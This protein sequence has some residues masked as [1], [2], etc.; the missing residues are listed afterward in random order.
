MRVLVVGAGGFVGTATCVALQARGHDVRAIVRRPLPLHLA[1]I[2]QVIVPNVEDVVDWTEFVRDVDAIVYLAARVHVAR[3]TAN[4]AI[5]SYRGVNVLAPVALA[6]AAA[7]CST[8]TFIYASSVKVHGE[9]SENGLPLDATSP[10]RPEGPYA[11]S[12]AEAEAKL[13]DVLCKTRT[14]L[15]VAV[16][17]L[18]Y[19]PGVR[20]N[21]LRLIELARIAQLL[22][23][24]LA[25][26]RNARSLVYVGNVADLM[27][28]IV[29]SGMSGRFMVDDGAP[30]STPQLIREISEQFGWKTKL[31][32]CPDRLLHQVASLLGQADVA[33]RLLGS[34]AVDSTDTRTTLG[35]VPR[36]SRREGLSETARWYR[37]FVSRR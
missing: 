30:V 6:L 11:N 9:R 32:R 16:L 27:V 28:R 22:P 1:T 10:M 26:L 24:P 14:S 8:R 37:Q 2:T 3:E 36:W 31:F 34:L 35:W 13:S 15:A 23:L 4:G 7:A 33:D 5:A 18:V 21:F 20:A 19:G 17:P 29:E 25:S 12:K